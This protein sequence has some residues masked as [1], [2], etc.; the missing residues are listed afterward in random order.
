[1]KRPFQ[2]RTRHDRQAKQARCSCGWVGPWRTTPPTGHR[3]RDAQAR[4]ALVGADYKAHNA[5]AHPADNWAD[6]R[7]DPVGDVLRAIDAYT[8]EEYKR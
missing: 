3:R 4:Y 6:P 1:V 5:E 2:L 8:P 7:S